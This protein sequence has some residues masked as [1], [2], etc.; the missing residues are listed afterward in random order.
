MAKLD[1]TAT[2]VILVTISVMLIAMFA[3]P[4]IQDVSMEKSYETQTATEN[5]ALG[6]FETTYA[7][8]VFTVDGTALASTPGIVFASD[9]G[10]ISSTSGVFTLL[11]GTVST[12]TVTLGD[13]WSVAMNSSGEV[14]VVNGSDTISFEADVDTALHR[15]GTPE[16]G[17]AP[18]YLRIPFDGELKANQGETII[19]FGGASG[20]YTFMTTKNVASGSAEGFAIT[21]TSTAPSFADW[22]WSATPDG[23]GAYTVSDL[24]FEYNTQVYTSNLYV[25]V[26]TE[27][28]VLVEGSGT[29]SML[30]SIIPLLLIV[31]AVMV[32]VRLLA[33]RE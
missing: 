32:A 8:S 15:V 22:M 33:G 21:S 12:T 3:I 29:F 19:G 24:S 1:S 13:T 30:M 31:A 2:G 20:F 26:P 5:Y 18:D 14:T 11:Y 17:F 6:A 7:D 4:V 10:R 16:E 25:F 23:D 28:Y 27:Y 9:G